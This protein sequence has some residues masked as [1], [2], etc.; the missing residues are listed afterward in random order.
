[1]WVSYIVYIWIIRVKII[2][3]YIFIGDDCDYICKVTTLKKV[4]FTND[5]YK[6]GFPLCSLSTYLNVFKEIGLK[7]RVIDD[8]F[9]NSVIINRLNSVDINS[10][11]GIE[12]LNILKELK[13][14]VWMI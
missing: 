6:C 3:F 10:I 7:I 1:M 12:A 14:L 4:K 13:D 9:D 8:V 11:T 5:V 2:V